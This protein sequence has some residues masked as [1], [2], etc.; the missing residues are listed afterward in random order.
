[1]NNKGFT[2]IELIVVIAI[3]S[4]MA[5]L[6]AVNMSG[7]LSSLKEN[8]EQRVASDLQL[9]ADAYINSSKARLASLKPC[10]IISSNTL[11]GAGFLKPSNGV[12]YKESIR[13]CIDENGIL[14]FS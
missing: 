10:T 3:I 6:L 8:E 7:I 14:T 2:L 13:V 4:A 11:I 5:G 1:M 9:A 12:T